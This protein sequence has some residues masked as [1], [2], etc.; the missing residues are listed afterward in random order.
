[1]QY[2]L[3]KDEM[4]MA[5][6]KTSEEMH[7]P[8]AVLMERAGLKIADEAEKILVQGKERH[9]NN[10]DNRTLVVAGPGNNGG[11]GFVVGRILMERGFAVDFVLVGG[12]EKT[13]PLEKV[14]ILSVKALAPEVR[15]ADAVPDRDY[16]VVI[17]AVFGVSLSRDVGGI[18]AKAIDSINELR[19]RGSYV[20]SVDIPSGIDADTGKVM[21]TAVRADMTVA[22]AFPKVGEI[23][24]PGTLYAGKLVTAEIGITER[25]LCAEPK[26]SSYEEHEIRL[27]DRKSDSNKGTYGKVLLIAGSRDIAGAAVLA[28]RAALKTGCGMVRVFTHENNRT[29]IQSTVPEALVT[30]W[31]ENDSDETER[32]LA[33]AIKWSTALAIGPGLGTSE[34]A[35]EILETALSECVERP[36]VLDADALNIISKNKELLKT[37]VSEKV[38]TPHVGEMSRL[39]GL[40]IPEVKDD[41]IGTAG[42]FAKKHDLTCVL[43][44][45]RTVTALKDGTAVINRNGNNGLATAGSG[46]VLTGIIVSLIAQGVSPEK[47]ASLGVALHGKA[48]DKGAKE[49]GCHGLLAGDIINAIC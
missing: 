26:L 17:D 1:M 31:K 36:V 8:S 16:A 29:V 4:M 42:S 10:R 25:S 41:L 2:I 20:I 37:G 13:S 28:A 40:S 22:C 33:D 44:D 21:G 43:K 46:D 9:K 30:V 47:A 35:V 7:V 6:R 32:A 23:M 14:Q 49:F 24:L 34:D 11:D 12:E 48:G 5:D 38:I 27:P 3:S 39:T 18:Y 45:S 19:E 15:I